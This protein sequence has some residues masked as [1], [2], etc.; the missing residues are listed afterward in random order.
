MA[1]L[2][3]SMKKILSKIEALECSQHYVHQFFRHARA[4]KS[5][6]GCGISLKFEL[7]QAFMHALVTCKNEYDRFKNEGAR[8]FTRFL[9]L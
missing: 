2:P 7:F 6:L 5:G 3:A 8:G 1:L 9:P 4:D